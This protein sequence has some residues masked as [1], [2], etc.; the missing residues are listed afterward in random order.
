MD[1]QQYLITPCSIKKIYNSLLSFSYPISA[2]H[3][4]GLKDFS[5]L[6]K[7]SLSSINSP[8][9]SHLSNIF[10]KLK[11]QRLLNLKI[12]YIYSS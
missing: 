11:Y 2:L 10:L 5:Q 4:W 9:N 7:I 3:K 1:T 8:C 6:I 12:K